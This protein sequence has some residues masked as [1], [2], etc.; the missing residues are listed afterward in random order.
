MYRKSHSVETALLK[1]ENDILIA[2]DEGKIVGV[3][4]LDLSSAFD[5]VDHSVLTN[6]LGGVNIGGTALEWFRSYLSSRSQSVCLRGTSSPSVALNFSVPQGSVLG[7][8]LFT[9]YTLPL[10]NIIDK[11]NLKF[12]MYADDLQ[13]YFSC[14]PVQEELDRCINDLQTCICDMGKWMKDSYLKLCQD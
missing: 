6:R 5:T 1:V 2:M 9:V 4:L 13:L 11:H 14:S 10:K 7:T 8:H 12:H 3:V